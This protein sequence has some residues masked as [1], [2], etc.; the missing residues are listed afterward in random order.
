[1]DVSG[2][3]KWVYTQKHTTMPEC[4]HYQTCTHTLSHSQEMPKTHTYTHNQNSYTAFHVPPSPPPQPS[5]TA[6]PSAGLGRE[7]AGLH[8]GLWIA[9]LSEQWISWLLASGLMVCWLLQ[10]G[11]L[12]GGI[13]PSAPEWRDVYMFVFFSFF[14]KFFMPFYF[15]STSSSTSSALCICVLKQILFLSLAHCFV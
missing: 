3:Y 11:F 6:R 9:K 1:M 7:Q 4:T 2:K 8:N 5:R 15:F 13:T 14:F 12:R 10:L